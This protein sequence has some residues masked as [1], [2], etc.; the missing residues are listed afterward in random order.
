[1]AIYLINGRKPLS[2]VYEVSGAKNAGPKLLITSLVTSE[3][4]KFSNIPDTSDSEKVI[5]AIK[6][7]GGIVQT[8]NSHTYSVT[9]S[10][11]TS[12]VVPKE[13]MRARQSVLFIGALLARTGKVMM[14][15]LGG[16]E[17]GKR[18]ID[19]LLN[20]LRAFGANVNQGNNLT[21]EFP[22]RPHTGVYKFEKNS[23]TATESLLIA[24]L[25][26]NGVARVENVA[27]E[28][29]VDN[30]IEV[31]NAMGA[32]IS[33]LADRVIEIEGVEVL[34]GVEASSIYDRLEAATAVTLSAMTEGAIKIKN[35]EKT[36]LTSYLAKLAEAGVRVRWVK[37]LAVV[38]VAKKLK[39]IDIVTEVHPGFMTDWH[40]IIA[41]LMATKF[42]GKSSVH[43]KIFEN[44]WNYLRELGKMGVKYELFRPEGEQPEDYNFNES[45]FKNDEPHA[46]Y[47]F[48]PTELSPTELFS[49]DVRA[50]IDVLL[51]ALVANGQSVVK[52][53]KDH[54]VRG[55]E[56]IVGKLQGLGADIREVDL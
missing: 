44:R 37:D 24:L 15:T 4:C 47:I 5:E 26:T 19:R 39:P 56:N 27:L 17:I 11:I 1:M 36:H 43:E 51:A 40:P 23:H 3:T 38:S 25:H 2:G 52:D 14:P 12:S 21:I 48:G 53:P 16:D 13:A 22:E 41:L 20:A 34:H 42:P 55:Y 28:P 35:A 18:P 30:L 7:F 54:I 46:A 49:H 10:N 8:L 29:E 45:E 50:G 33:R 31:L 32:R 9:C 6:S